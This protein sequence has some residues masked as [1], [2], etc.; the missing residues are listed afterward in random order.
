MSF[1]IFKRKTETDLSLLYFRHRI[2]IS[3]GFGGFQGRKQQQRKQIH[4]FLNPGLSPAAELHGNVAIG[5]WPVAARRGA[6]R[7]GLPSMYS[8]GIIKR[9][10]VIVKE[11]TKINSKTLV[12]DIH[13]P[14]NMVQSKRETA[15]FMEAMEEYSQNLASKDVS[16]IIN[17]LNEPENE[18]TR[19]TTKAW[20]VV[21]R[22]L[23]KTVGTGLPYMYS[24]GI[25]KRSVV[26]VKEATKINF[27]KSC[28]D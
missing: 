28:P 19:H 22:P 3:K 7:T 24:N 27:Q 17:A 13:S 9:S 16:W 12:R 1:F 21:G 6:V 25:I 23:K 10:V 2:A 5:G 11:A 14:L 20:N 18:K 4:C 8:N 26:I 15:G